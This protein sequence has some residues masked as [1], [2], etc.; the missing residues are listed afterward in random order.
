[1]G[2]RLTIG[3]LTSGIMDAFNVQLC[4][5]CMKIARAHNVNFVMVP[6]KYYDRDLTGQPEIMYEYQYNTLFNYVKKENIDGLVIAAGCIGCLTSREMLDSF[7]EGFRDVP[8]VLVACNFENDICVY[9][10]NRDA[11]IEGISYMIEKAGCENICLLDGG[12]GNSDAMERKA[13]YIEA[14]ESHGMEFSPRMCAVGD[15]SASP[16]T[17]EAVERIIDRNPDMDGLFCINDDM[18]MEAYEALKERGL[19]PGEDVMVMGYDNA[20]PSSTMDPPLSTVAAEPMFLAERAMERIIGI[21]KGE[22]PE[23]ASVPSKFIL[24][25]SMG[26]TAGADSRAAGG[27][28]RERFDE[29][30]YKYTYAFGDEAADSLFYDFKKLIE[31]CTEHADD[32]EKI[33]AQFDIFAKNDIAAFIDMD[34]FLILMKNIGAEIRGRIDN[35]PEAQ[36]NYVIMANRVYRHLVR[37]MDQQS[38]QAERRQDKV[39]FDMKVFVSKTMNF[40]HGNDQSWQNIIGYLDWLMVKDAHLFAFDNPIV[41]LDKEPFAPPKDLYLKAVCTDGIV[42][43][44]PRTR[45]RVRLK[46][47]FRVCL[48]GNDR[49]D[50]VMFPLFFEEELY[51]I[52]C[53]DLTESIFSEGDFVVNQL[54]AAAHMLNILKNYEDTNRKNEENLAIMK[55][56]NIELDNLSRL[57]PLTGLFNRRGFTDD[58]EKLLS[59]II[60]EGKRGVVGYADMNNLKIVND[61]FGHEEGDFALKSIAEVLKKVLGDEAVI[62]RIGGDEYAFAAG[63]VTDSE[64]EI[65]QKLASSFKEFNLKTTKPYNVTAS[66][67]L[68]YIEGHD[69]VT[70]DEALAYADE[71]LYV[72]KQ[73]KDRRILKM[74]E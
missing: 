41:H 73:N 52:F 61:R 66:C 46:D 39:N 36:K 54:G 35:S 34:E 8:H 72:A 50:L 59:S 48:R 24:R 2:K 74:E 68:Y 15:L 9:Y 60:E 22:K 6:G 63:G 25:D 19:R 40:R 29:I 10:N 17:R 38:I 33:I 12:D 58:A 67:G 14:L 70:L 69:N 47:L 64:K 37:A 16:A 18:A 44:V 62:G 21:L 27:D 43:A 49:R 3:L 7:L 65:T 30:F 57:D 71:K 20:N 26:S 42:S 53:F 13:A 51:G 23:N 5:G 45:Q 56:N 55:Q 11:V 32:A 1:M 4:R 28:L 31:I